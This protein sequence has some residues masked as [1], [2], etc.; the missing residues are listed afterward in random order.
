MIKREM[1]D[2]PASNTIKSVLDILK[3]EGYIENF[4]I[5]DDK[6][7]GQVRVY[8]KYVADKSAIRNIKR[9]SRP[10]LRNYVTHKKIPMVLRGKGL[11][12]I[13]TSKGVLTDKEA[14]EKG[15]GGEVIGYVW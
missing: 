15:L 7:Q 2:I 8:L 11:A 10:G 6:K 1:V 14:R 12:I 4:K 9:V 5:I 13:S 3:K